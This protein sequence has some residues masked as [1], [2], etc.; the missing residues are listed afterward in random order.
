[1][2]KSFLDLHWDVT[3]ALYLFTRGALL[4]FT[5][6]AFIFQEVQG[7]IDNGITSNNIFMKESLMIDK[8]SPGGAV[9]SGI[10]IHNYVY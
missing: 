3:G 6:V 9:H 4:L 10:S 8:G 1:M 7:Y 2:N 5:G